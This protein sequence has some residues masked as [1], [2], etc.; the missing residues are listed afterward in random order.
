MC[1]PTNFLKTG[2]RRCELRTACDGFF[3]RF[4]G[5]T[6][7][8]LSVIGT[9]LTFFFNQIK[10]KLEIQNGNNHAL[11][12]IPQKKSGSSNSFSLILICELGC[13]KISG[14]IEKISAV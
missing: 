4:T 5:S 11:S 1:G 3:T 9:I 6:D 12:F 7:T 8:W 14:Y 2:D 10:K 13:Y